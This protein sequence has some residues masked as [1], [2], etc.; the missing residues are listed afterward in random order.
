[1]G[2]ELL[3]FKYLIVFI[4]ACFTRTWFLVTGFLSSLFL[5][6]VANS[7]GYYSA[8]GFFMQSS[9]SLLSEEL[10]LQ[11]SKKRERDG[12][13]MSLAVLF[14]ATCNFLAVH[15]SLCQNYGITSVSDFA[16]ALLFSCDCVHWS[17][18]SVWIGV[19]WAWL[20][21]SFCLWPSCL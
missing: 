16:C 7:S 12:T 3:V 13:L 2:S 21:I 17:I 10:D 1:M 18:G 8:T 4:T 5:L 6:F 19:Y 11:V 20:F 9:L 15:H 14:L